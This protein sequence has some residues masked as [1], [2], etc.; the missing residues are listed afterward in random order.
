[1]AE[2]LFF[3]P[4]A[5]K[6]WRDA[7]YAKQNKSFILTGNTS[8]SGSPDPDDCRE[9]FFRKFLNNPCNRDK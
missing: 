9:D 6:C 2:M 5:L 8:K 1:M 3:Q 4:F 7:G